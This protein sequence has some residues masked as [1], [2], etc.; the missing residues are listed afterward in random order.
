MKYKFY[1]PILILLLFTNCKKDVSATLNL[2]I[3]LEN[4]YSSDYPDLVGLRIYKNGK[5]LKKYVADKMPY[6]EHEITLNKLPQAKYEFEYQNFFHQTIRK[7]IFIN[8]SKVYNVLIYP[9]YCDYKKNLNKSFIGKLKSGESMNIKFESR[10]CFNTDKDSIAIKKINE[11]YFL[12]IDRKD[13]ELKNEDIDFLRKMEAE[14]Y[15]LPND[16]GCTTVDT[17]TLIYKNQ[18]IKFSDDTCT[19]N[20]WSNMYQKFVWK[21]KNGI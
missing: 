14:L 15:E 8:Q 3:E 21:E 19:W 5:L 17:Y 10:G 2:K 12:K 6:I 7:T 11:K 4:R 13:I 9:D 1:Y 16:I 18:T 20:A